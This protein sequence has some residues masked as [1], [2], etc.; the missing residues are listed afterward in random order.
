MTSDCS[1]GKPLLLGANKSEKG[2]S[3]TGANSPPSSFFDRTCLQPP[4]EGGVRAE[5]R[6]VGF[7]EIPEPG[8]KLSQNRKRHQL[9][10]K[11]G[12]TKGTGSAKK[13]IRD[14]I[15]IKQ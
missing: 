7:W 1:Q 8:M 15:E 10:S 12:G 2:P 6:Q 9:H 5:N 11:K 3:V 13:G 4:G 14:R